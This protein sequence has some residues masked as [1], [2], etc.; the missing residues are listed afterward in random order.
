MGGKKISIFYSENSSANFKVLSEVSFHDLGLDS[1]LN[2]LSDKESER[3]VIMKMMCKL[4]DDADVAA[5]R[6]GVF[7]DII[8]NPGMRERMMELLE[9]V[10]YLQDFIGVRRNYEDTASI[11]D[12]VHRLEEIH[13]Y[14]CV[15]EA[16][17]ECLTNT[18]TTSYGFDCLRNYI[19]SIYNDNAFAQMKEDIANLKATTYD[20]KSITLGINLNER[21]EAESLGL[22]SVNNKK[23]TKSGILD[24]FAEA[25]S[26]DD[27]IKDGNEWNGSLK[28]HQ[29]NESDMM[30]LNV[31]EKVGM[32]KAVMA[33]P[34]M[35]NETLA[36]VAENDISE[37]TPHMFDRIIN[38]MLS[39]MAKRLREVL[40]KYVT[41]NIH[42]I[43]ALIPEFMYYIRWAEY[44]EKLRSR[45][46]Q[47]T[48]PVAMPASVSGDKNIQDSDAA[49]ATT[50]TVVC[51][52]GQT[53]V[54]Q[55]DNIGMHAKGIYNIRLA[56]FYDNFGKVDVENDIVKNDL[57]FDDEHRLYLLTGANR[58]G[59]TTITQAIGQ[60]YV[61]AQGGLYIPGEEF[62]FAPIDMVYTHFPA[63]E[64]KTIDL[65]RLGE[66]CKRF[67]AIFDECTSKSLLLLNETFSTTSF[68]E[69]YYIAKDAVRAILKKGARTI[70]N[71]HMHKLA[72]D[73]DEFNSAV[74]KAKGEGKAA[75]LVVKT[76]EGG[77]R[78][79]KVI[80]APPEGMSYAS[81]IAV[82]YG[83]TYDML[84]A[85]EK[86]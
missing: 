55:N 65:G 42:N 70:Y 16:I 10:N 61:L 41:V 44:I 51:V 58:G 71:T 39:N 20:L 15:I 12:L 67:K 27:N 48:M 18:K 25:I 86:E 73:A 85:E 82:K 74:D 22:I 37:D 68:E 83:V 29:L 31:F 72:M 49:N 62:I 77:K 3:M 78:S 46:M 53:N 64:D 76:E 14:I 17:H 43:T 2:E 26:K 81:D 35:A 13:E 21:F 54:P 40:A 47:F 57:D 66:E 8:N 69:G 75:S 63:D 11:W 6:I 24:N 19:E 84:V 30:S 60:L 23:F 9:K 7:N 5:Y 4:T 45:G 79:F 50:S 32:L 38:H 36:H 52:N 34:I 28:Y 80:L 59:K 1:I 33:N 56:A